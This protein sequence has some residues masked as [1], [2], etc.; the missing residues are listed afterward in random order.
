MVASGDGGR[1]AERDDRAA[2]PALAL[3][4]DALHVVA[5]PLSI[6]HVPGATAGRYADEAG[7]PLSKIG[8]SPQEA[9]HEAAKLQAGVA[10]APSPQPAGHDD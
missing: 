1:L 7:T 2:V 5:L 9:Q 6:A 3:R 4:V 10:G 8:H